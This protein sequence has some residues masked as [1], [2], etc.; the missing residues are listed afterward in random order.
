MTSPPI[1]NLLF[2]VSLSARKTTSMIAPSNEK[3]HYVEH[4]PLLLIAASL[5]DAIQQAQTVALSSW[6]KSKGWVMRSAC[7]RRVS[8]PFVT[9][10]QVRGAILPETNAAEA[11]LVNF[12]EG[13]SEG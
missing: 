9:D 12:D 4:M 7:V 1:T 13:F 6:P 10:L 8:H 5:D 3:L 2:A 11:R